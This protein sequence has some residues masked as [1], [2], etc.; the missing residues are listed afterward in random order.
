MAWLKLLSLRYMLGMQSCFTSRSMSEVMQ[1]VIL[2]KWM[3][4][5]PSF[6]MTSCESELF[7]FHHLIWACKMCVHLSHMPTQ[8]ITKECHKSV[9][10][11]IRLEAEII[12]AGSLSMVNNSD[13]ADTFSLMCAGAVGAIQPALDPADQ[14]VIKHD[15]KFPQIVNVLF[16]S[17]SDGPTPEMCWCTVT[18]TDRWANTYRVTVKVQTHN[19]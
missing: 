11:D 3:P 1:Y 15:V 8:C 18:W 10:S 6:L 19:E 4:P 17:L 16:F 12:P 2:H 13:A 7:S 14:T 9:G 5:F